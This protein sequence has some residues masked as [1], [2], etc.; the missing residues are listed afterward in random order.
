M[1]YALHLYRPLPLRYRQ[2]VARSVRI[3]FQGS[4]GDPRTMYDRCLPACVLLLIT[5]CC[6]AES[7]ADQLEAALL[8]CRG[9][10]DQPARLNCYDELADRIA[11]QAVVRKDV[12]AENIAA[13]EAGAEQ[14]FGLG[15]PGPADGARVAP[16]VTPEAQAILEAAR[17]PEQIRSRVVRTE[18]S[19]RGRMVIHL[20]ND[21]VWAE[22]SASHFKGEIPA[23]AEATVSREGL[24]WFRMRFK[25]IDGVVAVRR[26]Q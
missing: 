14:H 9:Q 18:R 11:T 21:Q 13:A 6:G 4:G 1:Q 12:L 2:S 3:M 17:E 22:T 8:E 7:A 19:R 5:A 26:V 16:D 23:G 20:E 15:D 25:D 24:G 10:T